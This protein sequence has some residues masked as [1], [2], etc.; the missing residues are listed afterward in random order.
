MFQTSGE[1]IVT[2]CFYRHSLWSVLV[3]FQ[4]LQKKTSGC[5][6]L[7]VG[8]TH[9]H[10]KRRWWL[11][12]CVILLS[13]PHTLHDLFAHRR[14]SGWKYQSSVCMLKSRRR[15]THRGGRKKRYRERTTTWCGR[16]RR[17]SLDELDCGTKRARKT[18]AAGPSCADL[19]ARGSEAVR[20][21]VWNRIEECS[22]ARH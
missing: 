21:R 20:P 15:E 22:S 11:E 3:L 17:E 18:M 5:F 2:E 7:G 19:A 6:S 10:C 13:F 4:T 16:C 9:T 14:R 1:S 8:S 12:T